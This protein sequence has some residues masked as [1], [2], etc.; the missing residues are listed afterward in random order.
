M[1]NLISSKNK[2][3]DIKS[4]I[5]EILTSVFSISDQEKTILEKQID[6]LESNGHL[7]IASMTKIVKTFVTSWVTKILK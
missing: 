7:K 4:I 2:T 3:I 6:F 5:I 1:K